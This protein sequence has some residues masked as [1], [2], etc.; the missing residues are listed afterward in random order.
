[1]KG[2]WQAKEEKLIPYQQY[3]SKL[4]KGFDEIDFTHMERDK[5]Q[6]ADALATL[7]SM[8]KT[9]YGIRVQLIR[10]EIKNFPAHCCS[11]EGEIDGN[12]WFYDIKLF[13]QYQEYPLGA[14]KVDM[15]TLRRLAMEFYLD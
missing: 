5:N 12:P 10:I 9:D 4:T 11:I 6:F 3:L 13:I 2:E 14:S 7:A 15:K 1:M 8:A